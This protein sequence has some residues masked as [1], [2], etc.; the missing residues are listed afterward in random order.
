ML[1]EKASTR[2]SPTTA[3]KI[4]VLKCSMVGQCRKRCLALTLMQAKYH[5]SCKAQRS[6][7]L[8]TRELDVIKLGQKLLL[9]KEG[10]KHFNIHVAKHRSYCQHANCTRKQTKI[11]EM[12]LTCLFFK[13]FN[14]GVVFL[15]REYIKQM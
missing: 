11:L 14:K 1:G 12:S 9:S 2:T 7:S 15:A 4:K 3:L 6:K 5:H 8:K 13:K 10:Q